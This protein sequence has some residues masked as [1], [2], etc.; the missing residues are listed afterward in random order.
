MINRREPS[1]VWR[2][3]PLASGSELYERAGGASQGE[4]AGKQ[5]SSKASASVPAM[6]GFLPP[7]P[8]VMDCDQM[9]RLNKPSLSQVVFVFFC[10]SNRKQTM[11][12]SLK[13]RLGFIIVFGY[14]IECVTHIASG[15]SGPH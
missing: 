9:C 5:C 4:Q 14:R 1:P 8:L 2:A 7:V 12:V 10:H 3:P 13:I 6:L 15:V 11:A